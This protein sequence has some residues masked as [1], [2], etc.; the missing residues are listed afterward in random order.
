ME[1]KSPETP[2]PWETQHVPKISVDNKQ[3]VYHT[4]DN[5]QKA[6]QDTRQMDSRTCRPVTESILLDSSCR[7]DDHHLFG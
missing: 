7:R 3:N 5:T 2:H 1:L 6:E 4:Y